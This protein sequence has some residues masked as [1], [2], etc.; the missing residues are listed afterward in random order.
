MSLQT[1]VAYLVVKKGPLPGKKAFQKYMYFLDAKGVPT[2]LSFRIHHFGPYSADLDYQ[3]DNL[4][5]EGALQ[6][7][8]KE[9]GSGFVIQPGSKSK[10]I[11]E[12]G[13]EFISEY[14]EIIDFVLDA[15]PNES[16]TLELWSTT[17]FVANS[18][19]KFYGGA[20]K[21]KVI[22]EVKSIKKEKF[23]EAEIAGAYDKLLDLKLLP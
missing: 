7:L 11:I 17:H 4:E 23:S 16:R 14:D 10:S 3:T 8:S 9:S 21:D 15:L 20:V 13:E 22:S 18:M 1:L 12:N 19:N 6:I 2:P 5:I